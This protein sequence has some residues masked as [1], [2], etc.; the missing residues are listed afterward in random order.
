MPA[1]DGCCQKTLQSVEQNALDTKT[2]VLLPL[3]AVAVTVAAF[4][5]LPPTLAPAGWVV[6]PQHAPPKSPSSLVSVLRV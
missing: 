2:V 4:E 6:R 1:S 5:V 3:T